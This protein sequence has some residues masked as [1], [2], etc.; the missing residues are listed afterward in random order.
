[1]SIANKILI[2][3]CCSEVA[4]CFASVYDEWASC[5]ACALGYLNCAGCCWTVCAPVCHSLSIGDFGKGVQQ[6]IKGAKYCAYGCIVGAIA[7]I[8]GLINC[9]FY[10]KK[11]FESGVSGAKDITENCKFIAKKIEDA[12]EIKGSN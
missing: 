2:C 11:N 3:L 5:E 8:D 12:F 7:P 10:T 1:M 4:C 9:I 6:L